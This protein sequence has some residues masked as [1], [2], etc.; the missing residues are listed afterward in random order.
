ML[1][2]MVYSGKVYFLDSIRNHKGFQ[3]RLTKLRKKNPRLKYRYITINT[4]GN[5]VLFALYIRRWGK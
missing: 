2:R 1:K 5:D 3:D 4:R